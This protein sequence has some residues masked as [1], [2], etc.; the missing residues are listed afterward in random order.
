M[1]TA[2]SFM[3]SCH[4]RDAKTDRKNFSNMPKNP[5]KAV[6]VTQ[7]DKRRGVDVGPQMG[8]VSPAV[9]WYRAGHF[10]NDDEARGALRLAYQ[11]G[12]D[13]MGTSI[14]EW[15][16]LTDTEFGAWMRSDALPGR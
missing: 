14:Q 8:Q 5:V 9:Y 15:M 4:P 7:A 2:P 6:A 13:G 3:T 1:T 16:G 11:Q 12:L 10:K